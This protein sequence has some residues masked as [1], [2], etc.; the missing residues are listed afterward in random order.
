VRASLGFDLNIKRVS[1]HQPAGWMHQH[2]VADTITFG[3][4]ALQYPQWAIVEKLRKGAPV[5][6]RVIELQ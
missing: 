4:Q 6:P 2:V 5:L 3:V 1:A